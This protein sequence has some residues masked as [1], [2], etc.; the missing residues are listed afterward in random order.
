MRNLK[1][2]FLV[3]IT[4]LVTVTTYASNYPSVIS[5][6]AKTLVV[7]LNDWAVTNLSISIL[8]ENNEVLIKDDLAAGQYNLR[9]YNLKNLPVGK[10]QLIIDGNKKVAVHTVEV[11]F[12]NVNIVAENARVY[13]RPRIEVEMNSVSLN[14]L[15]LNED[16]T[17][18]ISDKH[19][20]FFSKEYSNKNSINARFDITTLPEGEYTFSVS[21]KD[22][23]AVESFKK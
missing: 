12:K 22:Q 20:T 11:D 8:D 23:F 6:S 1:N 5:G 7:D 19:G 18:A 21:T 4:L 15:S 14:L 13:F 9:K 2:L 17:V 10:Y 16:V 3:A